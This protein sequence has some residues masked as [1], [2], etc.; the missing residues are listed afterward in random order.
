MQ[1]VVNSSPLI[2][3]QRIGQ[4]SLLRDL[5]RR[6]YIPPTVRLEVFGSD[7]VPSW[8]EERPLSQPLV[9]RVMAARLGAGEREAIAM[10]LETEGA[11]LVIDDLAARRL[12]QS[13]GIE[14]VGSLGLLLRA[15]DLGLIAAVRPLIEAMQQEEFRASDEVIAT[16]LRAAGEV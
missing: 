12:A 7:P 10:A 2:V 5:L 15:K 1:Y 13:L 14:V 6:A 4:F 9:P 8:V 11:W 16:I 3:F